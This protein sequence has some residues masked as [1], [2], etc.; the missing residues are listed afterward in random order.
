[1]PS[2][3]L[4]SRRHSSCSLTLLLL[5]FLL[6]PVVVFLVL[7]VFVLVLFS[8]FQHVQI[9]ISQDNNVHI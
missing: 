2:S 5:V 3:S 7:P 8:R 1:M 4:S 6:V 9:F